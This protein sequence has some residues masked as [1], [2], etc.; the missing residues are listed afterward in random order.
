L[1]ANL[2]DESNEALNKYRTHSG[3]DEELITIY[4]NFMESL[5]FAEQAIE[6]FE[7]TESLSSGYIDNQIS[8]LESL[9]E[10]INTNTM[11]IEEQ[12]IEKG[13]E[14]LLFD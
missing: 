14:D 1:A 7:T 8:D 4:Q 13:I 6:S 9:I 2:Y 12:A 10:W 3:D 5:E 11:S